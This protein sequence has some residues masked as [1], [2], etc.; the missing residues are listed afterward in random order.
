MEDYMGRYYKGFIGRKVLHKNE[1]KTGTIV[2]ISN[3]A[4]AI[5]CGYRIGVEFDEPIEDG[6][7]LFDYVSVGRQSEPNRGWWCSLEDLI[8]VD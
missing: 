8:F 6:H 2:A 1:S 3:F 4:D 5:E 7:D